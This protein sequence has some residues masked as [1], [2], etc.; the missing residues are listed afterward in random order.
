MWGTTSVYFRS[1]Q[2]F[3]HDQ[4]IKIRQ[5]KR[6]VQKILWRENDDYSC[7]EMILMG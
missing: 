5:I 4:Q 2:Q 6:N 1:F 7:F 3:F